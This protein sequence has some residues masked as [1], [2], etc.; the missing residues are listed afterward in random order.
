MKSTG[1]EVIVCS[2]KAP[3][4]LQQS[5]SNYVA[6]PTGVS[7]GVL[8]WPE[9]QVAESELGLGCV[10]TP[11]LNLRTEISSDGMSQ[12]CQEETFPQEPKALPSIL[13][14]PEPIDE[15]SLKFRW[16]PRPTGERSPARA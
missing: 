15:A 4:A 7:I 10:K 11:K 9:V 8:T 12:R 14:E 5:D 13:S 6:Y 3:A 2:W 1:R 16:Q